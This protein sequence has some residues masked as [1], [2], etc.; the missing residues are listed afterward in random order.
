MSKILIAG[1][2]GL[3]GTHL[4]NQLLEKGYQLSL[5]SRKERSIEGVQ[6]FQWDVNKGTINPEAFEGIDHVINLAGAGIADGRWTEKYKKVLLDSRIKSAELFHNELTK[7]NIQLKSYITASAIG[8]YGDRKDEML[9]ESTPSDGDGFMVYCCEQWEEA[10]S[11]MKNV[12]D[13]LVT[14]RIGIVL[15]TQGGALTKML[16]SYAAFVGSYF[17]DGQ[18]YYS[19]IHIDDLV[20][21]I[22]YSLENKKI[23]G[24]YNSVSP[25]PVTN[26]TFAN[27]IGK[28]LEKSALI[29][30]VPS[31]ALRLAMG[32][33]ADVVLNSNRVS[34][35]KIVSSG[36]QFQFPA[37]VPAL[38]DVVERKV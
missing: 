21:M 38:K 6:N 26:K 5:L 1:G 23:D 11:L 27:A 22:I 7:R 24:T 8:Y 9:T 19:W 29:V 20:N 32:E 10:G 4:T 36:F 16:P 34:A 31:F 18:Q 15:S 12:S 28:A 17:G 37:L 14:L 25:N 3:V 33:M 30:P 35:D 2:T 13:R